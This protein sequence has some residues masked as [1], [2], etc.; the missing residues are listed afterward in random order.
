MKEA[1]AGYK[2]YKRFCTKVDRV[3]AYDSKDSATLRIINENRQRCNLERREIMDTQSFAEAF[4]GVQVSDILYVYND[5]DALIDWSR[6]PNH[7]TV[8]LFV[9]A[10]RYDHVRKPHQY[11]VSGSMVK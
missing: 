1:Q 8:V 7:M 5:D 4:G 2:L 10:F 11:E 3:V 6:V 9:Y